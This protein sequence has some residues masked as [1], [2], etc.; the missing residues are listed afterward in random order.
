MRFLSASV[1]LSLYL[2]LCA[3]SAW[4]LSDAEYKAMLT[5]SPEFAV[6][7]QKLNAAWKAL[8]KATPAAEQKRYKDDQLHW[9]KNDRDAFA[10]QLSS[11]PGGKISLAAAY[12][13]LNTERAYVLAE[14]AKQHEN[15]SYVSSFSGT[16]GTGHNEAGGY[17]QFIPEGWHCALVVV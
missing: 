16:V 5:N 14:T 8:Q 13:L 12:A 1:V 3:S 17:Y 11:Q 15:A 6:S 10:A 9:I 4:A 7:D 2:F